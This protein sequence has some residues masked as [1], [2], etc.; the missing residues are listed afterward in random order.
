MSILAF[1]EGHGEL[2]SR[3]TT[4]RTHIVTLVIPIITQWLSPPDPKPYTLYVIVS[5]FFFII[6][7][8]P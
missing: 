2:V 8:S 7:K 3:S 4:P 6:T 5:I 1:L